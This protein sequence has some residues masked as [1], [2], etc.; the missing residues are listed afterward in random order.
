MFGVLT[1]HAATDTMIPFLKEEQ[2]KLYQKLENVDT[3][4]PSSEGIV[5][6][7]N[8]SEEKNDTVCFITRTI[9]VKNA[10]LIRKEEFEAITK[11]YIGR[12]NGIRA[13]N[14][15]ADA[16]TKLYIDKGYVTSRVY[17]PTQNIAEGKIEM[18]AVEGKV[19]RILSDSKRTS[20]AFIGLA[21]AVLHLGDLESALEQVNR[22][23][24][25][26]TRMRLV[27]GERVGSS[28]IVL[29]T[30]ETAPLFGSLGLNNFGSE[31]TGKYQLSGGV[32]WENFFGFSDILEIALNTTD[33]QQT[34]RKTFGNSYTYSI[35]L[36]KW[37][38]EAGLSRFTYSQTIRGLNDSYISH[39]ESEVY[40][41]DTTYK[42]F[43]T[44]TKNVELSG[45]LAQKKTL[46]MIEGAVIDSSTYNLTVGKIGGKFVYR[47]PSWESYL[48]LDY[49]HG[50]N[51]FH[52]TT[53]GAL[54]HDFSKWTLAVGSTKYFSYSLP[55]TYRFSAFAQYSN[56]LLY[57]VEQISIGGAYSVR[58]FQNRNISGNSGWYA[59]NDFAFQLSKYIAPYCAYDL[60]RIRSGEDTSGGML[61]S[62][63]LGLRG[64][65]RSLNIDLYH[66][67]PL[68][69]PD[70]TFDVEP[71]IGISAS[72]N[73]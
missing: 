32:V 2:R 60:G 21:D 26:E 44:R 63:T 3:A 36:G 72:V 24:S 12:C 11:E 50:L 52:P 7:V 16:F 69:A 57:S 1:G 65:Y 41:L 9:N 30:R 33:K 8:V 22:L 51:P 25:G 55:V 35:P 66:A 15:L 42:L 17:L 48:L 40:S 18:N 4:I 37:L 29:N 47:N 73:F 31:E 53:D 68:T 49:Y 38:W 39:G 13:L 14:S 45:S 23:R 46:S 28:D 61:T 10:T 5:P 6:E 54:K 56:D 64:Q 43:H 27:P 67:I 58:G 71:F 59:R 34:G 20:G 70:A 19:G 62:A